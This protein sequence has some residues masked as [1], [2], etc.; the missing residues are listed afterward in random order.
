MPVSVA[1]DGYTKLSIRARPESQVDG[2]CQRLFD[3]IVALDNMTC[4]KSQSVG[5]QCGPCALTRLYH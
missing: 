2:K 4:D 5:T 1:G 3:E